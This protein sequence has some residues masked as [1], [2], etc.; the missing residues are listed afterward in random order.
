GS[1][2]RTYAPKAD[3]EDAARGNGNQPLTA[4]NAQ[5]GFTGRLA[6][7]LGGTMDFETRPGRV[8]ISVTFSS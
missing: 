5:A 8:S 2:E 6:R 7:A 1:E 3:I 4:K